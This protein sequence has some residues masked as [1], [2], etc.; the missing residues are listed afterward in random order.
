M[1]KM[2]RFFSIMF[3]LLTGF[4]LVGCANSPSI[5]ASPD[6]LRIGVSANS[7]PMIYKEGGQHTGLEADLGRALAAEMGRTP[8]FVDRSW[9]R[10]LPSLQAGEIDIVMSNMTITDERRILASFTNP[11]LQVGQMLL[12]R[13]SEQHFY[14]DP[15]IIALVDKKIGVKAG[16]V[17]DAFVQRYCLKATR[18]PLSSPDKAISALESGRIDA[19]LHDAP[20][21]WRLSAAGAS[22]GIAMVPTPIGTEGLGWA[23]RRGDS[24]MLKKANATIAKWRK[25]GQLWKMVNR[26]VPTGQ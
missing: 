20:V 13:G 12:V 16:T 7:P 19:F 22:R 18:V 25:N 5:P 15:M 2:F 9:D 23:V 24:A 8:H 26:W 3:G 21:I 17:S 10:L 11:Y 6:V 1:T 4:L 14:Q